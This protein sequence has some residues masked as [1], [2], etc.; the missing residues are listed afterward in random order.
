MLSLPPFLTSLSSTP[1]RCWNDPPHYYHLLAFYCIFFPRVALLRSQLNR[2]R[3]AR[4]QCFRKAQKFFIRF[5][6]QSK[7][8]QSPLN[9]SR[10]N[11]LYSVTRHRKLVRIPRSLKTICCWIRIYLN[12]ACDFRKFKDSIAIS[13]FLQSLFNFWW[14]Q[15]NNFRNRWLIPTC[16]LPPLTFPKQ[17]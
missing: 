4:R 1:S 7:S 10:I 16:P 15:K 17:N 5:F 2:I 6:E 12:A 11:D 13:F 9:L 8:N 3:S 14:Q